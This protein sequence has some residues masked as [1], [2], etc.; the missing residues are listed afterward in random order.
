MRRGADVRVLRKGQKVF[1]GDISSLR[2]IKENVREM[3]AG[4]ECG[5]LTE[6]FTDY[7]EG[8]TLECFE[9]EQVAREL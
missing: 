8:D 7:Q 6:G 4:Y 5:I 2:H 9:M 1:E 3:A